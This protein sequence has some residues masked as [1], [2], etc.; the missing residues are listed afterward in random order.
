MLVEYYLIEAHFNL[1]IVNLG[2]LL[3]LLRGFEAISRDNVRIITGT[4]WDLLR[5][6]GRSFPVG[7]VLVLYVMAGVW[8]RIF[9]HFSGMGSH[10]HKTEKYTYNLS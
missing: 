7:P 4:Y 9:Q 2:S 6:R 1:S 5:S 3:L 8:N 10:C